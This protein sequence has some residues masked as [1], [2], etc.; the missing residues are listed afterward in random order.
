MKFE[1]MAADKLP[2]RA[3]FG[4]APVY[5]PADV[6]EAAK[7]LRTGQAISNGTEYP[8]KAQAHNSAGALRARLKK[9]HPDLPTRSVTLEINVPIAQGDGP[10]IVDKAYTWWIVASNTHAPT[11]RRKTTTTTTKTE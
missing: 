10:G 4:R 7:T 2:A 9:A 5:T 8:T 3:A 1:H 11:T 6:S